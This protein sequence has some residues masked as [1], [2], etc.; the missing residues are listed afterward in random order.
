MRLD[1]ALYRN[2]IQPFYFTE[3]RMLFQVDNLS[4]DNIMCLGFDRKGI[5]GSIQESGGSLFQG[6]SARGC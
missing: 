5:R 3:K 2:I 6:A 4:H 1:Y